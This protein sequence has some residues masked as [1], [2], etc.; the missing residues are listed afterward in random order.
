MKTTVNTSTETNTKSIPEY[1]TI[2]RCMACSH[3]CGIVRKAYD[4]YESKYDGHKVTWVEKVKACIGKFD[5][6]TCKFY[7]TSDDFKSIDDESTYD[8]NNQE[9][10]P[11]CIH[12]DCD[13]ADKS[14]KILESDMEKIVYDIIDNK[15][16]SS[17]LDGELVDMLNKSSINEF[18]T[19]SLYYENPQDK[20]TLKQVYITAGYDKTHNRGWTMRNTS[21]IIMDTLCKMFDVLSDGDKYKV[22]V[23]LT[24]NTGKY[25]FGAKLLWYLT[26]HSVYKNIITGQ[27]IDDMVEVEDTSTQRAHGIYN[28]EI[29]VEDDRDI[30]YII[31]SRK[32]TEEE[33]AQ[34]MGECA[35]DSRK[36]EIETYIY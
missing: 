10:T 8:G 22:A 36:E 27:A 25:T 30:Q 26:N 28:D 20:T 16:S 13:F 24:F 21:S 23:M 7:A 12:F 15:S 33:Y 4:V 17:L 31:P 2:S 6:E 9:H 34:Y 5:R 18:E 35:V 11:L 29:E 19:L 32:E 3:R 14:N 1:K